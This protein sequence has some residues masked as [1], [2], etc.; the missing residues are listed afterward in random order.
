MRGGEDMCSAGQWC[1]CGDQTAGNEQC[2]VTVCTQ[3]TAF[4]VRVVPHN[5]NINVAVYMHARRPSSS[6]MQLACMH[7]ALCD[8]K[9][10]KAA[11]LP[12]RGGGEQ[13]TCNA[14]AH[15]CTLHAALCWH[16]L[17]CAGRKR[18]VP[19]CHL[20]TGAVQCLAALMCR[21]MVCCVML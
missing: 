12:S 8:T 15:S 3:Q 5:G 13:F 1:L 21:A 14:A 17:H 11:V 18:T 2:R 6:G 9:Q 19:A 4:R 16:M 20:I 10:Q 7:P